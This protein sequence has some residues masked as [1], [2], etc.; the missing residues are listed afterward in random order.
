LNRRDA[1][2]AQEGPVG[3]TSVA[4]PT[5]ITGMPSIEVRGRLKS[6]LHIGSIPGERAT[7]AQSPD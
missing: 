2:G 6:P 3:A 5:P 1:P 7:T 4:H